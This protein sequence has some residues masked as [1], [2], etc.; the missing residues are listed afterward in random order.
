MVRLRNGNANMK[1]KVLAH[2]RAVKQKEGA[3][4]GAVGGNTHITFISD[5]AEVI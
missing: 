3:Q 4:S 2:F 1:E 5:D